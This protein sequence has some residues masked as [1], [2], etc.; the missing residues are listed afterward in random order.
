MKLRLGNVSPRTSALN[1][2]NPFSAHAETLSQLAVA[3]LT[4]KYS[5]C[6]DVALR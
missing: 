2:T 1:K 3:K 6:N 5:D 4:A